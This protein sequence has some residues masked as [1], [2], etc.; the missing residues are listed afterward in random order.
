MS[1]RRVLTVAVCLAAAVVSTAAADG[2][3]GPGISIGGP[4]L[5]RADG[6]VRYVALP[7][8]SGTMVEAIRTGSGRVLHFTVIPG[9][10]LG[11]P[12]VTYDQTTSGL[13]HDG[14]ALVLSSSPGPLGVPSATMFAVLDTRRFRVTRQITLNGSFAYDAL[15]PDASTMYLIQYTSARN[16]NRYRVRAYDLRRGRLLPGAIVDKREPGEAMQG[17]P[18]ARTEGPGGRWVYTLYD[19]PGGEPFIHALDGVHRSAVCID[20]P[21]KHLTN[22]SLYG[23]KLKVEGSSLVVTQPWVGRLAIVDTHRFGVRLLKQPRL[24]QPARA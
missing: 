9:L 5:L 22:G 12:F 8:E 15:A 3:L 17:Q 18:T 20:L 24:E 1:I 6:K 19:R 21:W 11:L 16:V 13:S 23:A 10:T 2:G 7:S 14:R 4:G